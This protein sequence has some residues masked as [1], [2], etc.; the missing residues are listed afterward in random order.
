MLAS[1]VLAFSNESIF[2]QKITLQEAINWLFTL[3]KNNYGK[4]KTR[5]QFV[6]YLL[7][8][9]DEIFKGRVEI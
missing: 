5:K 7:E 6:S 4:R 9:K 3:Y 8:L 2:P 1:C